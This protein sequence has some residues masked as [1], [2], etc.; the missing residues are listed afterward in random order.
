MGCNQ[1]GASKGKADIKKDAKLVKKD[2]PAEM[3]QKERSYS[4]VASK[5]P[6]VVVEEK[7]PI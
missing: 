5:P 7:K 6:K 4:D 1:S 2:K 3:G